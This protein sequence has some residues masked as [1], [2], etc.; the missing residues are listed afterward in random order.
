MK[1]DS[2]NEEGKIKQ[3]VDFLSNIPEV[4]KLS[5]SNA[6][7]KE[8]QLKKFIRNLTIYQR[9]KLAD[10]IF[11]DSRRQKKI[12][13]ESEK[14]YSESKKKKILRKYF[15]HFSS[16]KELKEDI[17]LLEEVLDEL[18]PLIRKLVLIHFGKNEGGRC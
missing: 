10:L 2:K 17:L 6:K 12:G 13:I 1:E 15:T 7:P 4:I 14:I 18:I 3:C 5:S 11:F 8:R 9:K 16:F